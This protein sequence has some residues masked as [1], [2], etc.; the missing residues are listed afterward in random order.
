MKI[1]RNSKRLIRWRSNLKSKERVGLVPTM[2]CLHEGHFALMR[3][4]RKECDRVILSLFVNPTQFDDAAD[5]QE[6]P[7]TE[8]EDLKAAKTL[9]VDAVF[10]PRRLEEI[11]PLSEGFEIKPPSSFEEELEGKIRPGHFDGVA[12]VVLRLF[13]LSRPDRAYFGEKDYQQLKLV[14]TLARDFQL[15]VKI[16]PVPTQRDSLGLALS[17]RNR[18]LNQEQQKEASQ[19]YQILKASVSLAE[20]KQ[21]LQQRGFQVE[22]LE[23]WD[24]DLKEPRS[25]GSVRWLAAV[26]FRGLRLIDNLDKRIDKADGPYRLDH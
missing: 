13:L 22:Y 21:A 23:S 15:S 7:V 16:R 12:N 18:R 9:G 8:R 11:Y 2:G 6:Y 3:K 19:L 1:L 26:R 17:S 24:P 10:L 20:A 14:E 4:A 5:L 25:R